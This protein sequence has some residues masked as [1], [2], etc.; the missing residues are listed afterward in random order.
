M[1]HV[2][3]D[4]VRVSLEDAPR[5][6]I[7]GGIVLVSGTAEAHCAKVRVGAQRG[8]PEELRQ[9]ARADPPP[10]LHLP[11]PVLR[12]HVSLRKVEVV[13]GGGRDVRH[14]PRV[15]EDLDLRLQA[16]HSKPPPRPWKRPVRDNPERAP[17]QYH[18]DDN[19]TQHDQQP[20][21]CLAHALNSSR[22]ARRVKRWPRC[23]SMGPCARGA[24]TGPSLPPMVRRTTIS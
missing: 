9:P 10:E 11:E 17:G 2:R 13:H 15:A 23:P 22:P 20:A 16:G 24:T 14:A 4:A 21:D 19:D 5:L 18:D 12:R 7:R 8:R 1:Q 3:V 6:W